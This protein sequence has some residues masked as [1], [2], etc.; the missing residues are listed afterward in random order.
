[1]ALNDTNG[2]TWTYREMGDRVNK[3]AHALI[4]LGVTAGSKVCVLQE[5]CME[6][7]CILLA[8]LRVGA[9]YVAL[10]V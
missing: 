2:N 1:M 7:V 10:D 8:I 5:P 6:C 3:L 9:V 4:K